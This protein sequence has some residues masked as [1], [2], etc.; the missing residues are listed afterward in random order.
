MA[1]KVVVPPKP[2]LVDVSPPIAK[3]FA[4]T[5]AKQGY[6]DTMAKTA[7]ALGKLLAKD[8]AAAAKLHAA[9]ADLARGLAALGPLEGIKN[10]PTRLAAYDLLGQLEMMV[11]SLRSAGSANDAPLIALAHALPD[12]GVRGKIVEVVRGGQ[13]SLKPSSDKQLIAFLESS[14]DVFVLRA[15]FAVL[16]ETDPKKARATWRAVLEAAPKT[17]NDKRVDHVLDEIE[18]NEKDHTAWLPLV[19]PLTLHTTRGIALGAGSL[20]TKQPAMFLAYVAWARGQRDLRAVIGV[21]S[22]QLYW[23][24]LRDRSL[25]AKLVVPLRDLRERAATKRDKTSTDAL[26]RALKKIGLSLGEDPGPKRDLGKPIAQ[27][28]TDGGPPLIVPAEHLAAWLGTQGPDPFDSGG[29]NDYERACDAKQPVIT[30][31]KGHGVVL[32]EQSCDVYTEPTGLLFVASGEPE[33]E[34][35]KAWKKVGTLAVG[36]KGIVVLDAT[37]V[38]ASRGV[39]RKAVKLAAGRYEVRRHH[40]SGFGGDYTA[41]RLV[42]A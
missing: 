25:A 22:H 35:A 7:A 30:I 18:H 41:T 32:A 24:W 4:K 14:T 16:F 19:A 17:K 33:E 8:K 15:A 21:I 20:I 9:T 27:V 13:I 6:V 40:P 28:G 3:A 1:K 23:A 39:N 31:G 34:V 11:S 29:T 12:G 38:G 36:A 42:R 26:D 37:E 2:V 10:K 5:L